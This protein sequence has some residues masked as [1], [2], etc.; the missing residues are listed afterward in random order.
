M[1][2]IFYAFLA[3]ILFLIVFIIMMKW[4]IRLSVPSSVESKRS[5]PAPSD[6]NARLRETNEDLEQL[7]SIVSHDLR[8]PLVAIGGFISLIRNRNTDLS[9]ETTEYLDESMVVVRMVENKIDDLLKLSRAGRNV[10]E[11]SFLLSDSIQNG[12]IL[13]NGRVHRAKA[14]LEVDGADV[15]VHGTKTMIDQVFQNL[16][17]NAMKY[18]DPSRPPVVRVT[19]EKSGHMARVSVSDNGIGFNQEH[20]D[21]IFQAFQRL[22]TSDSQYSGTGIGLAIVRK[23][24]VKLGGEVWAE[25]IP[26]VG[27]TFYLTI[28][29]ARNDE[30]QIQHSLN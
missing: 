30:V 9:P 21:R 7:L 4:R 17:S 14:T 27:S 11:E 12:W 22:H 25:S 18:S 29:L 28:P 3:S 2:M 19:V 16:F 20:A 6:D 13:L 10:M 15:L 26:G 23:I 8:E 5:I 24:I 1:I